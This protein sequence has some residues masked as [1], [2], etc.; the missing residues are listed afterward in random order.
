MA[1]VQLYLRPAKGDPV[2]LF[3]RPGDRPDSIPA[4]RLLAYA[5]LSA[6]VRPGP[7]AA[8]AAYPECVLDT[9]ALL[10]T[11]PEYI[12]GQFLPGVVTPLP[13]DP[14]MPLHHRR[15]SM[16][17]G[18]WPYDLGELPIRLRD[19]AGGT[20]D[21]AVIT[22][23]TRDGGRLT[24][25]MVLGLCGGVLDNRV[26]RAEPDPAAPHGQAWTLEDP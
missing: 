12:W 7:N 22:Q 19:L 18:N 15:I 10:T 17:G 1:R 13:F 5:D 25:P 11:L 6:S 24:I 9:A 20:M 16:G 14:A 26:L 3:R 8:D 4:L 23:L 2:F 21:V